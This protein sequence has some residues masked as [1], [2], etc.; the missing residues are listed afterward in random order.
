MSRISTGSAT[1]QDLQG[2]LL[3]MPSSL[4]LFAYVLQSRLLV[5]GY[6]AR[7]ACAVCDVRAR[8]WGGLSEQCSALQCSVRCIQRHFCDGSRT[9]LV[10]AAYYGRADVI[11]VLLAGGGVLVNVED[12]HGCVHSHHATTHAHRRRRNAPMRAHNARA[13]DAQR[14][15]MRMQQ[16][17]AARSTARCTDIGAPRL[18]LQQHSVALCG[19]LRPRRRRRPVALT[20]RGRE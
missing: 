19:N 12:K 8:V 7:T 18:M 17:S 1:G 6:H 14:A 2:C 15:R 11:K 4:A 9:P 16:T 13:D 20:R 5:R 10:S 3:H